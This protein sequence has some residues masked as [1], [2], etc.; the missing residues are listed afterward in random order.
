MR[1]IHYFRHNKIRDPQDNYNPKFISDALVKTG[2]LVD[3]RGDWVDFEVPILR[4]DKK[5]PRTEILIIS[6]IL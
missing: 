5:K 6:R 1:I 3:D 4:I 2:I